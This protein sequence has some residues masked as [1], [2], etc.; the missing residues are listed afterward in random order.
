MRGEECRAC[1]AP[2][3]AVSSCSRKEQEENEKEKEKEKRKE[4]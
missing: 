4:R 2:L 3:H 1:A